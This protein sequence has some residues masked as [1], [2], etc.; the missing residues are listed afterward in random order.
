M[1]LINR[2]NVTPAAVGLI[3]LLVSGCGSGN[4]EFSNSSTAP[5]T[6]N[7]NAMFGPVS[8]ATVRAYPVLSTGA[9]QTSNVLAIATTDING[10]YAV[11][12]SS[13]PSGPIALQLTGG[14]YT[15]EASGAKISLANK[16]YSTLLSSV[17]AGSSMTAA[18]GPLPDMAFQAFQAKVQTGLPSGTSLA[19]AAANANYQVSQAFGLPDVVGVLPTRTTSTISNNAQGQYALVIVSISRTAQT[20]GTDSTAIAAA[21]SKGFVQNGNFSNAGSPVSV[22]NASGQTISVTPPT[23]SNLDTTILQIGEGSI[24]I[25]GVTPPAGFTPPTFDPTPP[26]T[27]PST[28][29]PGSSNTATV[30]NPLVQKITC[31]ATGSYTVELNGL[32]D[33]GVQYDISIYENNTQTIDCKYLYN[34]PQVGGPDP[35]NSTGTQDTEGDLGALSC[36]STTPY[37]YSYSA[38]HGYGSQTYIE[39]VP[40]SDCITTNY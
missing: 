33:F 30:V 36:P 13:P 28:Y 34:T 16:T 11:T 27:A 21:Y 3:S 26:S 20:A 29:V 10:N 2:V 17:S 38:A 25:V 32:Y 19:Q 14:T 9:L 40:L 5:A 22:T 23:L 15:E 31:V 12:L 24:D 6:I 18:I 8:G 37:V 39:T 7:G 35:I 1:S 4:G